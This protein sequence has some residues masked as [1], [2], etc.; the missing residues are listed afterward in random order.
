MTNDTLHR[1]AATIAERA[2]ASA[3]DSYTRSLL[4]GGPEK[5]ARKFGEEAAEIVIA[6]VSQDDAALK[7]EAADVLFHL[8]V[9]LK[10]RGVALG[11]V[12]AELESR[13]GRS[14]HEEKAARSKGR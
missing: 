10:S 2:S 1:L 13:T 8:L 9:L 4:D 12:M 14:G 3:E 6:A 7:A 5:C 11:D